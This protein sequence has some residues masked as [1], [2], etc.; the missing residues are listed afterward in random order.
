MAHQACRI[1]V[2]KCVVL[3]VVLA[4]L[5]ASP[6]IPLPP[7][8]LCMVGG[9]GVH[10]G[11]PSHCLRFQVVHRS[12]TPLLVSFTRPWQRRGGTGEDLL[13]LGL[14]WALACSMC[15]VSV[16]LPQESVIALCAFR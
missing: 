5:P 3:P 1:T 9:G 2:V 8:P 12:P 7:P 16:S 10:C 11:G 4:A 6:L 13:S 15:S 14:A